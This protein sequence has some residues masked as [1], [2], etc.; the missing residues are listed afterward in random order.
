M[1]NYIKTYWRGFL[2][3]AVIGVII[4]FVIFIL[5]L[6]GLHGSNYSIVDYIFLLGYLLSKN[7]IPSIK[8]GLVELRLILDLV[9]NALYIGIIGVLIEKFVFSKNKQQ[10]K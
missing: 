2:I 6:I 10:N 4:P 7:F 1:L 5:T 9:L 8:L 3:G